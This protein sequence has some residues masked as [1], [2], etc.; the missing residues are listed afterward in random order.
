MLYSCS[1]GGEADR[2]SPLPVCSELQFI[3][4][5]EIGHLLTLESKV[6]YSPPQ[7]GEQH[8]S[9]SVSVSADTTELIGPN[10]G[11]EPLRTVLFQYTFT[12]QDPLARQ[13]L[14]K[15]Y[16]DAMVWLDA[17]RRRQIGISIRRGYVN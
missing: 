9:F 16:N 11:T 14:P 7:D 6:T 13:V 4:P 1:G 10:A 12:A 5:V 17:R 8:R 2:T 3:N 15:S